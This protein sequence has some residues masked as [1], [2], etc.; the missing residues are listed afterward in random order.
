MSYQSRAAIVLAPA[1]LLLFSLAAV[2]QTGPNKD[3]TVAGNSSSAHRRDPTRSGSRGVQANA[4]RKLPFEESVIIY[5]KVPGKASASSNPPD[6][7]PDAKSG[8]V[9]SEEPKKRRADSAMASA[10]NPAKPSRQAIRV[11]MGVDLQPV[12]IY[13]GAYR[14]AAV[15]KSLDAN[16][17]PGAEGP[18]IRNAS[19]ESSLPKTGSILAKRSASRSNAVSPGSIRVAEQSRPAESALDARNEIL[20]PN[21][22][23]NL[24]D[25]LPAVG[26]QPLSEPIVT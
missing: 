26:K 7:A 1:I 2:G 14:V 8:E 6:P 11:D 13:Y 10:N 5:Y 22:N 12:I 15:A 19:S 17:K 18:L 9:K 3:R 25:A 24:E 23:T 21:L 20:P 4:A 16:T